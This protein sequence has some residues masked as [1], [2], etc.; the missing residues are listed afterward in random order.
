[1]GGVILV[2]APAHAQTAYPMVRID[3][4]G[5]P[6]GG[7]GSEHPLRMYSST[8]DATNSRRASSVTMGPYEV[9]NVDGTPSL[10]QSFSYI[11][12][13]IP[14]L[15]YHTLALNPNGGGVVVGTTAQ[16]AT[17]E[18]FF[19]NGAMRSSSLNIGFSEWS[20]DQGGAIELRSSSSQETPYL[21]FCQA[22]S[23]TPD[24]DARLLL[25][26][27][28]KLRFTAAAGLLFLS[29]ADFASGIKTSAGTASATYSFNTSGR[30]VLGTASAHALS[31]QTSGTERMQIAP[32]GKVCI[33]CTDAK[34]YA[35]AVAGS[36]IAEKVVVKLRG[37]WPDYVFSP[38]YA[39]PGIQEVKSYIQANG[40]LPNVP[41][42]AQVQAAGI[43]LAEVSAALLR[44]LEEQQLYIIQLEERLSAIEAANR[45]PAT[46]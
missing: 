28:K 43:D 14:G 19:V 6:F 33:G 37:A 17:G 29:P 23:A 34:G 15:R 25:D 7:Q 12:S 27:D 20:A 16:P 46:K 45:K 30:A 9:K 11:Q 36:M 2:A 35:L 24:Y 42:Q 26:P 32:D 38:S 3:K 18:P 10:Q 40:H 41:S 13:S 5:A 1:M 44:K 22:G 21:D 39:L 4:Q 31:F 8:P